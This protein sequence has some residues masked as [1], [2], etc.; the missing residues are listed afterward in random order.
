M[1]AAAAPLL[2]SGA[3]AGAV[4]GSRAAVGAGVP[5]LG[6]AAGI[7]TGVTAGGAAGIGGATGAAIGLGLIAGGTFAPSNASYFRNVGNSIGGLFGGNNRGSS[8]N[9]NR[10]NLRGALDIVDA[11]PPVAMPPARPVIPGKPARPNRT[12]PDPIEESTGNSNNVPV[13]PPADPYDDWATASPPLAPVGQQDEPDLTSR[14]PQHRPPPSP[15]RGSETVTEYP[16]A[17]PKARNRIRMKFKTKYGSEMKHEDD[18]SSSSD[19]ERP[20][21]MA[22]KKRKYLP[23]EV[24]LN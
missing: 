18:S 10:P 13:V 9:R 6:G 5:L 3:R 11:G 1:V 8:S 4:G 22:R 19:E 23:R 15:P 17:R 21:Y 2:A 20:F 24:W 12:K 16:V 14:G 7:G